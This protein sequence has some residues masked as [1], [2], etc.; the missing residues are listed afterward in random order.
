MNDGKARIV[1]AGLSARL[2]AEAAAQDGFEVM[3]LD[4]FGDQDTRR[5]ATAGWRRIGD[6]ARM[7]LDAARCLAAL[8]GLADRGGSIGWIAGSGF[9]AQPELLEC[10]ASVLPLLGTAPGDVARLRDPTRFFGFLA[11]QDIAHPPWGELPS[12]EGSRWLVKDA[13]AC[14]GW[15]VE[16]VKGQALLPSP[17]HYFQQ[18][19]PG[20]PM[21]ATF[22]G[23]GREAVVLGFNEM[24]VR[25]IGGHP[26]VFCGVVGS[27][28]LPDLLARK[29]SGIAQQLTAEFRLRGLCSLDFI[30]EGNACSVLEVNARPP[31]SLAL[32]PS[33]MRAHVQACLDGRLPV[34]PLLPLVPGPGGTE[35]VFARRPIVVDESLALQLAERNDVHDLPY[36]GARFAAGD[37]VCSLS[38]RGPDADAVREHLAVAREALLNTLENR[39]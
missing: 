37:P 20:Q 9:E 6:A 15:H 10:G 30:R 21:S 2:M 34:I 19:V 3:A 28:P 11:S 13:R 16:R 32:Y 22:I 5:A 36:A 31:A 1:V 38:A 4:L 14:G 27:V 17:H 12:S 39:P 25:P 7:R 23:N 29:L 8:H 24:I 26:F 33:A 18:E 35:I